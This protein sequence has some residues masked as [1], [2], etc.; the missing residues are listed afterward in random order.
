MGK[1]YL[2]LTLYLA[3]ILTIL[4]F[5][6]CGG[7]S[8]NTSEIPASEPPWANNIADEIPASEPPWANIIA[9]AVEISDEPPPLTENISAPDEMNIH[10]IDVDQADSIL[11]DYGEYEVLIDGGNRKDGKPVADY[12]RSFVDGPIDL[13]IPTHPDADH[14]GGL[15]DVIGIFDVD[16]IIYYDDKTKTGGTYKDFERVSRGKV[17]CKYI[18]AADETISLSNTV[19]IHIIPPITMYKD[20][21]DNSIVVLLE[22]NKVKVLFTGDMEKNSE[23]DLMRRFTKVDV[24]KAAHHG[25]RTSSTAQFMNI[26]KPEYVIISAGI[27]ST[28]GH[29]HYDALQRYLNVGATIYGTFKDGTI[30]IKTDGETYSIDAKIDVTIADAGDNKPTTPL[31]NDIIPSADS[32]YELDGIIFAGN[33][34]TKRFHS[35]SCI[36]A[37]QI[38]EKNLIY[39]YSTSEA[40]GYIPCSICKPE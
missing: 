39:F 24:L 15:I 2:Q 33:K 14:I 30:V 1:K 16:K 12:I 31:V 3:I 13:I 21:N 5:T 29:P 8:N 32:D 22:Y 4:C 28:Y 25:S 26:V 17:N 36:S 18:K 27:D 7:N 23:R 10:F 37:A 6:G 40:I 35:L 34:S 11:I 38:S 9:E 19:S 20:T